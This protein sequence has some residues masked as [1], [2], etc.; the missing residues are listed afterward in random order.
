[1]AN[2]ILQVQL[3]SGLSSPT[4]SLYPDGSDIIANGSGDTLTEQVN[5]KG[6]YQTTVTEALS[7]IYFTKV[8]VGSSVVATG[9]VSL[10][11]DTSTYQ[12]TDDYETVEIKSISDN[13]VQID[14]PYT[15]TNTD[16]DTARVTITE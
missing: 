7:G 10:K 8:V 11:N 1:M 2:T 6:L 14:I 15:Y 3:P 16:G 9:W 13:V 12:V 4:L 5:R